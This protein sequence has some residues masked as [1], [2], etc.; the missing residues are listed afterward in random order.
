MVR[1]DFSS[2][3]FCLAEPKNFA[4]EPFCAVFQKAFGSDKVCGLEGGSIKSLR[5]KLFV[6]QCRQIS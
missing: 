5:R 3:F 6:S 1:H 2:N 4:G